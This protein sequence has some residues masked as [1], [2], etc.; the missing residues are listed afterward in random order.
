MAT[1]RK[2]AVRKSAQ[3]K[4]AG[5]LSK[6]KVKRAARAAKAR[7][8]EVTHEADLALRRTQRSI[9]RTAQKVETRLEEA[10][11]PAKRRAKRVGGQVLT[12]LHGASDSIIAV[13]RKAKTRL[14]A[15]QRSLGGPSA[16]V[17][18]KK[19]G[20]GRPARK[21]AGA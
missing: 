14:A 16:K 11:A 21:R 12:A 17:G 6:A 7:F 10:K 2:A 19:A 15:A 13:A 18:A 1:T 5:S 3:P 4:A 9:E 8:D 20:A